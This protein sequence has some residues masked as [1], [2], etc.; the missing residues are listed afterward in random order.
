[1]SAELFLMQLSHIS[2]AYRLLFF[3]I[4]N[5]SLLVIAIVI[6][7]MI[8]SENTVLDKKDRKWVLST[9]ICNTLITALG[10][11]LYQL[12]IIRIDFSNN[13]FSILTDTVL[14]IIIMDFFMFCFHYLAHSLKWLHRIHNL[15]HTHVNTNIYSLFVLHPIETL[16]FGIIWLCL[17]SLF[18]FNY[19]SLIL[20][21][22][23]NL[24][25]GIFGHLEKNIFPEF[26][27]EKVATRWISNTKFHND[28]HKNEANNFGFY[29]TYWDKIFKTII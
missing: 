14:L 4:E 25:Y 19:I 20:Y 3:L 26:W 28:H 21:L 10:F 22:F 18:E 17:I 24:M 12:E 27:S 7:K 13:L 6:G 29:F 1:M 8:E 5:F 16:G 15:H 9:L 11:E 23:L 2:F